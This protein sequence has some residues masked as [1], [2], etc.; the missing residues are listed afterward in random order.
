MKKTISLILS[1]FLLVTLMAG[2]SSAVFGASDVTYRNNQ[3]NVVVASDDGSCNLRTGPGLAYN[4]IQPIYNGTSLHITGVSKS[5]QDGL[6]W[7]QTTY[8]GN[9]GW[10]S[11][12]L[13]IVNSIDNSSQATYDVTVTNADYIML[14]TG[15][16]AEYNALY[17]P[18]KGQKLTINQTVTNSFDGRCWGRTTINNYTGW[19][20]LDWTSRDAYWTYNQS[21][22]VIFNNNVYY[23]TVGSSDGF[24]NLRSGPGL[25][26]SVITPVYNG[27][28]LTVN[29]VLD[30]SQD[31]LV[32]GQTT[33]NG[34]TGWV[35]MCL[36]TVTDV[37]NAS[38]ATYT[39]TVTDSSN[40]RL[41][42]GPGAE[43]DELVSTI[44][45][46]TVLAIT[47]TVVNSFD[48]RPWGKTNINGVQGWVSLDWTYREPGV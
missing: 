5:S 20:S 44:P 1:V 24:L 2:G 17:Q 13:T 35:S 10:I 27:T 30:N 26:N 40:I 16:G 11:M 8:N 12:L 41:R 22:D 21:Q 9:T 7:G 28:A 48:G 43:Y 23:A 42:R 31:G 19:I 6:V 14:R 46:G 15:P 37:D 25:S 47:Q 45:N 34:T 18:A 3:M 39:V 4:I 38:L 33:Y 29:A 32:W 36:T